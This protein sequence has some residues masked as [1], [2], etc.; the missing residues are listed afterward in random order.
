MN[1][2]PG[3][4][5]PWLGRLFVTISTNRGRANENVRVSREVINNKTRC[6][7]SA[8]GGPSLQM[9]A[10]SLM[11]NTPE[12]KAGLLSYL[13]GLLWNSLSGDSFCEALFKWDLKPVCLLFPFRRAGEDR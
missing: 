5:A 13:S 12:K 11:L 7:E 6:L 9:T 3:P 8:S 4:S 2:Q 1:L 10:S